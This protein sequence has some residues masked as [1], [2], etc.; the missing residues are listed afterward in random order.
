MPAER[1]G[2]D[3]VRAAQELDCALNAIRPHRLVP[4]PLTF[5]RLAPEERGG[6]PSPRWS[7]T[8]F[9]ILNWCDGRRSLAEA[10]RLAAR[11][12]R[13]G[14]SLCPDELARKIDPGA[15]SMMEYFEFLRRHDYVAW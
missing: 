10:C 6:R 14:R 15:A 5:D 2:P 13:T 4:G 12:L 9:A 8:L 11:E 3:T 7:G 1:G